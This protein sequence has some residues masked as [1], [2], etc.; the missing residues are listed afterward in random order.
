M[1]QGVVE[2]EILDLTILIYSVVVL[3]ILATTIIVFFIIFQ[4]RKNQLLLDKIDQQQK[5]DEELIKTQ[6]EI[7]EET[8]KHI[9]RELHDNVG[10]ML[11]LATMQMKTVA[12][13]VT[14]DIKVKVDNT[15]SVLKASLEEVRAL[16]KSLNS[17]VIFN[18]GFNATVENEVLRL[19]KSG[20]IA[21]SLSIN[22]TKVS[23]ENKKDEIILFRILQEFFSNTLKYAEAEH[24][25]VVLNYEDEFLNIRVEDD[26]NGFELEGVPKGSGLINMEKRAELLNA[27]YELVS[28]LNKGTSLNLVYPFRTN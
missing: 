16:S 19:N 9:G 21:S 7:Q 10:Q 1:G 24:L 15:A 4:K 26:G 14:D 11:V 3:A 20:L 5:F 23:F 18:L 13:T 12:S 17:D 6:Q 22:G 28:Q 2:K 25:N 8:L 27:K